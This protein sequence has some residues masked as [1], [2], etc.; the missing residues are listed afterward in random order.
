MARWDH[1]LFWMEILNMSE[2]PNRRPEEGWMG[3]SNPILKNQREKVPKAP[4]P[5][6]TVSISTA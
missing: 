4:E 3:A 2:G 5:P 6:Q 1:I